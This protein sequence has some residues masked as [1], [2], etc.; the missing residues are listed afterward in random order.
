MENVSNNFKVKD[1][2]LA[3]WGRKEITLAEAEMPG[4]MAT[5]AEFG[6]Q[7]PFKVTEQLTR[8]LFTSKAR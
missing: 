7:Q 1:I 5:R 3:D 2:S 4:L 8:F 6:P